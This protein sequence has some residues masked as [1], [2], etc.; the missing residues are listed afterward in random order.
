MVSIPWVSGLRWAHEIQHAR[1]IEPGDAC[2]LCPGGLNLGNG[3]AHKVVVSA[4][5]VPDEGLELFYR[6]L[7]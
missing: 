7:S 5:R 2:P 4:Q 6:A 1:S 3:L